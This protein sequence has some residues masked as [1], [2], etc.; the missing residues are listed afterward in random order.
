[1][2]GVVDADTHISEP[3][4]MWKLI[5]EKMAPRRPALVGLPED[6]WFGERNALWLIDGN[7]FPKPA[8]KGSYRLVTPSAQKAEKARGDIAIASRELSDVNARI[9]DMDR[10]GVEVQVVYPTLFLVYL[11]DDAELETALCKAYN[12]WLGDACAKSNGRLKFVA[13]LPL[14]SIPESL[15]E[16]KRCKELGAVGVFY[17]GIEGDKTI[18]H[19]YFH[20]VYELAAKLDLAICIHTGS[21]APWMLPYFEHA[22]NHTFAHGRALPIIAFRDLVANRIPE[23]FPGLRFGFIEASAGWAPFMVHI[24]RRLFKDRPKYKN[25]VELFRDYN[26]YIACEADEDISYL[27]KC[28]GEEHIVIGSDYGHNDPSAEEKLIDSLRVREDVPEALAQK[29][30]CD[31][32][33]RLYGLGN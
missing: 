19:P 8:G 12:S 28:I 21:G 14:R 30:L 17:R 6:T 7:I 11:T 24:L 15:T 20:P 16:M 1:M 4:A 2:R 13:V 26:L 25:S 3:E 33:R 29:I 32:P 27:A 10:L 5:D 23:Q 22:R 18:D 9:N 31:N